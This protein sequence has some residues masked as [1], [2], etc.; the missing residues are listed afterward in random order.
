MKL[1]CEGGAGD[2]YP[3]RNIDADLYIAHPIHAARRTE[4]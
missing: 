4:H 1:R 3:R 2:K